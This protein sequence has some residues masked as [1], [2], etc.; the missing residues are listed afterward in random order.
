L[1]ELLRAASASAWSTKRSS[2]D[3]LIADGLRPF[4]VPKAH[5][6]RQ[7]PRDTVPQIERL[8]LEN[9]PRRPAGG[10]RDLPAAL[11]APR[12]WYMRPSS[13]NTP[14]ATSIATRE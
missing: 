13:V 11:R 9:R 1:S 7:V 5:G 12:R 2:S 14:K 10:R 6:E 3:Q 8:P 4:R